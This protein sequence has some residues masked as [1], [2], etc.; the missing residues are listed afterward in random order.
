MLDLILLFKANKYVLLG[1]LRK[2]FLMVRL[3]SLRDKNRF[4]FF[5]RVNNQI[6][7]Y[8]FNTIIFGFCSSPFILNYVIK[9][10]A[11]SF[12]PDSCTEMIRSNFFVDNL[13]KTSNDAEELTW[14]Y[15]QCAERMDGAHFELRSYNTNN[16]HLKLLMQ[17]D[18]R[19]ITHGCDKDKVLGYSYS[20]ELDT[21][22]LAPVKLSETADTKRNILS[23]SAKIFDPLLMAAPVIVKSKVLISKLWAKKKSEIHWDETV[24]EAD[25]KQWSLISKDLSQLSEIEFP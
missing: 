25:Q 22:S 15:N 19:F 17:K 24:E 4:C 2:A 1:D 7:C 5:L 9:H 16:D 11:E 13:V 3:K 12:P 14:L 18:G 8:R 21:M 10:I 23:E 20:S 6:R